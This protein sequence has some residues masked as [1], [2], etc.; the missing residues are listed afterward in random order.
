LPEEIAPADSRAPCNP[1][2]VPS[3]NFLVDPA[4][5]AAQHREFFEN[6]SL[7]IFLRYNSLFPAE[8]KQR[9]PGP[10]VD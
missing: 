7:V 8:P 5:G 2:T 4:I 1:W 9:P 6:E 10:F 3:P